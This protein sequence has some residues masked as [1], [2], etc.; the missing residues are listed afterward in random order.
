VAALVTLE[1]FSQLFFAYRSFSLLDL[2]CDY[3][4]IWLG[5]RLALHWAG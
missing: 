5:G 1:E 4:G 2:S 3:L